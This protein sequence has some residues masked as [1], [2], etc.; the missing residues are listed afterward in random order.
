[1]NQTRANFSLKALFWS[2]T[3]GAVF[4]FAVS[5]GVA[6][7]ITKAPIPF[8]AKVQQGSK[9]VDITMDGKQD[10]N[11]NL[12]AEGQGVELNT[13]KV[14]TVKAGDAAAEEDRAK[15][16]MPKA[17]GL[18]LPLSDLMPKLFT[19]TSEDSVFTAF[20]SDR[21]KLKS[22]LK[23]SSRHWRTIPSKANFCA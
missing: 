13:A 22:K 10:P 14:A 18:V 12:Y 11:K 7:W 23:K 4:A 19:V 3:L 8:V 17:C 21:L 16:S 1:M 2:F 20:A 5:A 6:L 15:T 9:L